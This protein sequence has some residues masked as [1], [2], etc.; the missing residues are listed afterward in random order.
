MIKNTH[1]L[2]A[3][4]IRTGLSVRATLMHSAYDLDLE[5]SLV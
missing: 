3:E 2:D 5:C 4:Y 1:D